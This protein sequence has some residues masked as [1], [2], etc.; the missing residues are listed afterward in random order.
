M[1]KLISLLSGKKTYFIGAAALVYAIGIHFGWWPHYPDLDLTLFGAGAIT[2]RS[3]IK[4][5]CVAVAADPEFDAPGE[6]ARRFT[7]PPI[8][9]KTIGT[10]LIAALLIPAVLFTSSCARGPVYSGSAAANV[11]TDVQ[12]AATAALQAY[13][14]YKAGNVN[15]TWAL[16]HG[17]YAYQDILRTSADV[18]AF[19]KAWT[20]NTG[21]S[22][23]LANRLARIF[24]NSPAPPAEKTAAIAVAAQTVASNTAP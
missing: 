7:A 22:Q 23:K 2:I 3:A 8:D 11:A 5:L 13:A 6:A 20:G 1:Q 4:K 14:Q 15:L 19:V 17:A 9:H 16:S 12:A 21:D 24:A 18:K 10:P